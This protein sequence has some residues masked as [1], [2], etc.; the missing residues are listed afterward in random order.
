MEDPDWSCPIF[1]T[2]CPAWKGRMYGVI[3]PGLDSVSSPTQS[4]AASSDVCRG[5]DERDPLTPTIIRY[6]LW[7]PG[8]TRQCSWLASTCRYHQEISAAGLSRVRSLSVLLIPDRTASLLKCWIVRENTKIN[9]F[10]TNL[11]K[12]RLYFTMLLI[13]L[14]DIQFGGGGGFL[15]FN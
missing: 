6:S 9:W 13:C 10:Q 11:N 1:P 3:Q 15:L 12:T 14:L 4:E 5:R 8:L 7:T 2:L